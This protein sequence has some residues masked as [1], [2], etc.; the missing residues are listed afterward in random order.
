MDAGNT[1]KMVKRIAVAAGVPAASLY[2]SRGLPPHHVVIPALRGHPLLVVAALD[3]AAVFHQQDNIGAANRGEAVC[4]Y[5][6]SAPREQRRHRG[7][8]QLLALGVEIA[9]GLIENEDLR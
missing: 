5:E 9:R 4:D 7:L 2:T 1:W 3:D 8:N 6:S